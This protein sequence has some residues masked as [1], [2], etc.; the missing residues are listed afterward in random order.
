[1]PGPLAAGAAQP[2]V[3]SGDCDGRRLDQ[4]LA[5]LIADLTRSAAARLI[6]AG[7]V[8]VDG[9]VATR[10]S[11]P[12]AVRQQIVVDRPEPAPAAPEAQALP[13]AIVFEDVDLVVIDKPAGMVV[14]PAP[15][16]GEGTLVNALLHHIEDLS[17]IGGERRPGIVHRL[18]KGTS[19]L[20]VVAKHDRA[21]QELARQFS[22]REVEKEYLALVWGA[23]TA[24]RT[25]DASV[26]RD[27]RH[28]QRMS[29][30]A[31]RGRPASTTIVEVTAFRGVSLVRLRIATGRTH[32]IRVHLQAIGHPVVGDALY[33]GARRQLPA[34][35]RVLGSLDRPF[36]HAARLAFRHPGDGRRLAFDSPLPPDL[37]SI[38]A[39]LRRP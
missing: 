31:A 20:M 27:P 17:G 28:R 34:D 37:A 4:V 7:R 14:H 38:V 24:G 12:V 30:R 23:A 25:I 32:Q 22:Q 21:H 29:V 16:H 2:V 18:D 11:L 26:G 36:L 35:L 19:G 1:M 10:A 15:G 13:L 5:D 33:G 9:V 39:A 6:K 8:T 3:V